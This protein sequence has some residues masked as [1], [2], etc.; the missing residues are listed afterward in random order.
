MQK[1]IALLAMTFAFAIILSGTVAATNPVNATNITN[2]TNNIN[3]ITAD[4]AS[5]SL[6]DTPSTSMPNVNQQFYYD[7]GLGNYVGPDPATGVTVYAPIPAG[8]TYNSYT[9]SQGTY[10]STTGI[11]NVG[12][13]LKGSI[14]ELALYV[15]PTASLA[16]THVNGNAFEYQ[17]T[18]NPNGPQT[19]SNQVYIPKAYLNIYKFTNN[20]TPNVGQ[21]YYY[22]LAVTNQGPDNATGVQVS[23]LIPTGLTFNSYTASQGTYN[24]TT[25]IWNIGNILN[26]AGAS[27]QLFVTPTASVAGNNV[28]NTANITNEDQYD[29]TLPDNTANVTVHVPLADVSVNKLTSNSKPNVGQQFTYTVTATNNGPDTATGVQVTDLIPTGLTFNSYT[30]N[31]GTYNSTTGIW[32]IGTLL[33]GTN[34]V[35]H[36]FVTPTASVSG[37]TII[38][39]AT[40]TAQYEYDPTMPDTANVTVYIPEA[41]IV[42]T[43]TTS[44]STPNVGQMFNYTVTAVNNGPDTATGVKVTDHIPSGLTFNGWIVRRGTYDM[45][46]GIWNIGTLLNGTNAVLELFVTPTAAASGHTIINTATKTAQYEYDPTMPDTANASISVP[47]AAEVNLTKTTSN[48]TPNVG[49]MF[50]YTVTATNNGPF[51][52][53]GVIVTD[54][55]PSGLTFNSYTASQGTYNSTSGVWNVGTLLNGANAWLKLFITPTASVFGKNV[56][57]IAN[58]TAQNEYDPT[59]PDVASVTVHIPNTITIPQLDAAALTIELY[60]ESHHVL[61]AN[62]TING[63]T[64]SMPQMLQLLVTGTININN[65]NLNP[66]TVTS[67]NSPTNPLTIYLTGKLYKSEY[68]YIAQNIQSFISTTGRAPNYA[69]TSLG[70]MPFSELVYMYSEIIHFYASNNRLPNY[71]SL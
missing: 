14:A 50:N 32:N 55:I 68:L 11:W 30:A 6:F 35:L 39:T 22:G 17:T 9:A 48:T 38:N 58:K 42:V 45:T 16:G 4:P 10:N 18:P 8:M 46:T 7:I 40:K 25:G 49:Q 59:T 69:D 23:D 57:N 29:P 44:N 60:F 2:A 67:V 52:A 70:K 56:T 34:V 5:V 47:I 13:I 31:L 64:L 41:D 36:L 54:H 71:V 1:G 65:G 24:S 63:I 51:N 15:T 3:T 20:T 26:G 62:V 12:T 61:P 28:T 19:Q 43:K 33:N 37:H 53:T 66:L 27:I 21:Q